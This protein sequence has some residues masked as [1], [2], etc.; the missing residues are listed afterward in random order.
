MLNRFQNWGGEITSGRNWLR[1]IYLTNLSLVILIVLIYLFNFYIPSNSIVIQGPAAMAVGFGGFFLVWFLIES[2]GF[3]DN[4]ELLYN[5]YPNSGIRWYDFSLILIAI[6]SIGLLWRIGITHEALWWLGG[7]LI[8]NGI[9]SLI[10]FRTTYSAEALRA[11]VPV[12]SSPDE[13][14][15]EDEQLSS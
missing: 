6:F 4:T 11:M 14:L 10:Q 15:P 3:I 1:I 5:L 12:D 7:I 9:L 8:L 2:F 13:I